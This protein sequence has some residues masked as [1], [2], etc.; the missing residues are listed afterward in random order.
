MKRFSFQHFKCNE[1]IKY[2]YKTTQRILIISN[3]Q[4]VNYYY[5][6]ENEEI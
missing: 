4:P 5:H 3:Y 6:N 2:F 1:I